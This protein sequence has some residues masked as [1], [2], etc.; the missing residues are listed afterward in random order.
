VKAGTPDG[1]PAFCLFRVDSPSCERFRCG[2]CHCLDHAG[3]RK[4]VV[5]S[6]ALQLVVVTA[7]YRP[8]E[9]P[10]ALEASPCKWSRIRPRMRRCVVL[11][12]PG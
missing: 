12:R 10:C 7:L 5:M 1:L 8:G 4:L 3:P 11:C 2:W 6:A 9:P